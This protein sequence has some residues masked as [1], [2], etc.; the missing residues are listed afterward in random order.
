[1]KITF[2]N[3]K[4]FFQNLLSKLLNVCVCAVGVQLIHTTIFDLLKPESLYL[5]TYFK[6]ALGLALTLE[7]LY[8]I[9]TVAHERVK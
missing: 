3:R 6:F 9:L 5:M 2:E 8:S 4:E 1:M 7:A